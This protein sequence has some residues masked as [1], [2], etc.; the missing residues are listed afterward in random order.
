MLIWQNFI[1]LLYPHFFEVD[2][3]NKFY[4]EMLQNIIKNF[5]RDP[6]RVLIEN[7]LNLLQF[8]GRLNLNFECF[9]CEKKIVNRVNIV[10][11][12]LTA[13]EN[14]IP[15]QGFDINKINSLFITKQTT[16]LNNN[17]IEKLYQVLCLGI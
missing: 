3:I 7:Y 13:C 12:Y 6:K 14:C 9:L 8:E 11:G 15:T 5:D 10:R 4:F 1:K 17:E 2:K 16:L